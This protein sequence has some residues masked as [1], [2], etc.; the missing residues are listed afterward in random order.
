VVIA[1]IV[2]LAAMLLPALNKAKIKATG[3]VCRS[4][5]KQLMAGMLMYGVDY[6]DAI[7]PTIYKGDT[8]QVV[9]NGGGF[10]TGPLPGLIIPAT[11][12]KIEAE[13]R[14]TDALRQSPLFKYCPAAGAYHCPGDTRTKNNLP[15]KGWAY[16]SYSK[17]EPMNGYGDVQVRLFTK[18]NQ[19]KQPVDSFTFIEESDPRGYNGGTWVMS[20]IPPAWIDGFAIFHGNFTTFAFADGHV[21]SHHWLEASTIKAA[22]DFAHGTEVFNWP[23]GTIAQ[24][25]DLRWTYDHY[26]HPDW[27]PQ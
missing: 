2:I 9:L 5:H 24:N 15:G 6:Q 1:I 19:V 25:R 8:G 11:I 7:L 14:V 20:V 26:R 13:R 18:F 22:T 4:N 16:D 23:G 17:S 21:D 12:D 3:A 27:Q 10:W